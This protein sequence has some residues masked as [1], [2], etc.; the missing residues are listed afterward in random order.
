MKIRLLAAA[1][2][3][4]TIAIAAS[5]LAGAEIVALPA[6]ATA[7]LRWIAILLIAANAAPRRSLTGWILVG[8]LAGAELGHDAPSVALKLQFLGT[9]FQRLIRVINTP[10]LFGTC[11]VGIAGHAD[12][13]KVVLLAI[14]SPF[15]S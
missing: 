9:I 10:L 15:Y 8:L 2:V 1:I 14:T 7:L 3:A 11:V 6:L 4:G 13:K 12:W 5:L